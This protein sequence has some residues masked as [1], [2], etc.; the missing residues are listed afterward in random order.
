V[1]DR[2]MGLFYLERRESCLYAELVVVGTE[3]ECKSIDRRETYR[4][5]RWDNRSFSVSGIGMSTSLDY[6]LQVALCAIWL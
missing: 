6:H 3:A 5:R 1:L 2:K 4:R